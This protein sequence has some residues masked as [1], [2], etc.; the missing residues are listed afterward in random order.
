MGMVNVTNGYSGGLVTYDKIRSFAIDFQNGMLVQPWV[1]DPINRIAGGCT[2]AP[3]T[4][5]LQLNQLAVPGNALPQTATGD[6][7]A[8]PI[9]LYIYSAIATFAAGAMTA[10]KQLAIDMSASWDSG[11][12]Q[13]LATEFNASPNMYR[14]YSTQTQNLATTAPYVATL[15]SL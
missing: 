4:G 13:I 15:T 11:I 2:P 3:Q 8:S 9:T 1:Q 7:D 10:G 6:N 12:N 14:L 5:T